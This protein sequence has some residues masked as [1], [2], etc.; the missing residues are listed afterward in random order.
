MCCCT[1]NKCLQELSGCIAR[2]CCATLLASGVNV[3]GPQ[4]TDQVRQIST[5]TAG[6]QLVF[7]EYSL[8]LTSF[9]GWLIAACDAIGVG[10]KWRHPRPQLCCQNLAVSLMHG[11][12]LPSDVSCEGVHF[13]TPHPSRHV[14][15]P[16]NVGP[17]QSSTLMLHTRRLNWTA[18]TFIPA[19]VT[20]LLAADNCVLPAGCLAVLVRVFLR[21]DGLGMPWIGY[22]Q[23]LFRSVFPVTR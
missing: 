5:C 9:Q 2:H 23:C 7:W 4:L 8:A 10:A 22:G 11:L 19:K 17:R 14:R 13:D 20:R 18:Q 3:V 15:A 1:N 21:K 12:Q 16:D 6:M